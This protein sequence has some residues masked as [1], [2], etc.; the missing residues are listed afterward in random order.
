MSTDDYSGAEAVNFEIVRQLKNDYDFFW[1]SR[2]GK[3]NRFLDEAN[4]KWIKIDRLSKKEVKR[5]IKTYHPD[6]LHAT[7]YRASVICALSHGHTPYI[8]HIH[9]NSPW[10]KRVNLN[11]LI[12]LYAAKKAETILTVSDSIEREYIFSRLIKNKIKNIG[13]PVS[14]AK[15]LNKIENL[16]RKKRY[17]V[18]TVARLTKQ[19]NPDR[20]L[21]IIQ[22]LQKKIPKIKCV[23]VGDGELA[24]K[25]KQR[26][27]KMDVGKN[28]DFVGFQKN[29]YK[30]MAQSNIFVLTSDW[31]GY[32]LAAFEALSL[33]LPCV[34]SNVGGLVDIVDK[35]CGQLCESEADF[36][37]EIYKLYRNAKYYSTKAKNALNKSI[38]LDNSTIFA[39][40]IDNC[41]ESI[42]K[43]KDEN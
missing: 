41:Y 38:S 9:N 8:S 17:D 20:F 14:R 21:R 12:F 39:Q 4:I 43:E 40:S 24:N 22:K 1:V 13:N 27:K 34:V 11:S 2:K 6:I 10:I 7:D 5:I 37:E 16:S 28:I 36:L 29:P 32:G 31:E 3:I 30:Y 26:A 15:I 23:W 42:L 33:G 18:C 35:D 25:V 19:K